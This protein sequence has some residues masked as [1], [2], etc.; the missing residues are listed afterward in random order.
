MNRLPWVTL[1]LLALCLG[2]AGVTLAENS[3]ATNWGF[4]PG[5]SFSAKETLLR[6]FSSMFVHVAYLHLLGNMVFLAAV[7]PAVEQA[8]ERARHRVDAHPRTGP[9]TR[10]PRSSGRPPDRCRRCAPPCR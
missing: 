3:A 10:G 4:I 8:A 6:L 5:Y 1:V 9:R 7:G 2:F